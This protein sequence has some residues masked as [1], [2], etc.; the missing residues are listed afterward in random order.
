MKKV[1]E[2]PGETSFEGRR[3]PSSKE[4]AAAQAFADLGYDV[5]YREASGNLGINGV[6]TADLDVVGLGTVE[7]YSPEATTS[8]ANVLRMISGKKR[9]SV[10]ILVQRDLSRDE[11]SAMAARLWGKLDAKTI[12]TLFFQS[13]GQPLLRFNRSE[14][15]NK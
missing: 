14:I 11:M 2:K 15:F 1:K 12:Q 10:L 5:V 13:P 4:I 8:T 9:Q 6:P 7:V 3:R